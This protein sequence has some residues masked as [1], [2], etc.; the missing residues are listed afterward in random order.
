MQI[1]VVEPVFQTYIL[2]ILLALTIAITCKKKSTGSLFS[3]D[4]TNQLKGIA[5]LMVMF[6][7]VGYFL[8]SDQRFTYPLSVAGGKGVDIFL[9]LSGFG[10]TASAL[11]SALTVGGFYRKR[12]IKLFVPL[13]LILVTYFIL[14]AVVLDRQYPITTVIYSFFGW[15]PRADVWL[16]VNSPLWYFSI[17]LF[18]YL[19][20]PV[21]FFRRVPVLSAGL[22]LALGYFVAHL[23]LPVAP[24][25]LKL[26]RLHYIAFPLGVIIAS[27]THYLKDRRLNLPPIPRV[28]L[29]IAKLLTV[30]ILTGVFCYTAI[31]SGVGGKLITEQL[32][33][34]GSMM[35]LLGICLLILWHSRFLILLGVYSYELY[36]LHW[37]LMSRYDL[38]FTRL[39]PW[40]AMVAYFVVL[41]ILSKILKGVY[42]VSS[43]RSKN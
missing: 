23:N 32:I 14:D 24:D 25:L 18:Y 42:G 2:I 1:S 27:A 33:S 8:A 16:D 11:K 13:W 26:Y 40:L 3:A 22:L 39:P 10:L 29:V 41:L 28:D 5:I 35:C 9:F 17:I 31:N 21:V 6:S 7:H 37:P 20:F 43:R 4:F 19:L 34:I 36:L 30:L 38:L 15:F 12:L